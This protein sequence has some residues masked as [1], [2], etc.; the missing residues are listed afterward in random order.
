MVKK[1]TAARDTEV[2][3]EAELTE[4]PPEPDIDTPPYDPETETGLQFDEWLV[5]KKLQ[6]R[7]LREKAQ[8]L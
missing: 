4:I 7:S 5:Q 2:G 8:R 6:T 1:H 3:L